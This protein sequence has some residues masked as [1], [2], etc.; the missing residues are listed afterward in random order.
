[1]I[2]VSSENIWYI[3]KRKKPKLK[4]VLAFFLITLF[5]LSAILYNY[6]VVNKMIFKY[7]EEYA[8][9]NFSECVNEAILESLEEDFSYNSLIDIEK[10]NLGDIVLMN[11]KTYEVNKLSR[12]I[13]NYTSTKLNNRFLNGIPVPSLAFTGI[14]I[15]SGY[16]NKINLKTMFVSSV[17]C[18]FVSKFTAVGINQTLHSIYV[19]VTSTSMINSFLSKNQVKCN[20][21][22]LI[23]ESILIGKVPEIYLN[24]KLF[25]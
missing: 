8:I 15:L 19:E 18:N 7:C 3:K 1:M 11:A 22:V 5:I 2:E 17:N 6:F 13:V 4:K 24:S 14:P 23:C 9:Y 25:G 10:N 21:Q 20:T 12:K 16:G